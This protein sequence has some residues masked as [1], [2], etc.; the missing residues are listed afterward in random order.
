MTYP[1]P[2]TVF[3][4][5]VQRSRYFIDL[6]V[7]DL[8]GVNATRLWGSTN[9]DDAYGTLATSGI[10]GTGGTAFAEATRG[11]SFVSR[12]LDRTQLV[13]E[14]HRGM[15]RYYF[16]PEDFVNPA[17][18][19]PMPA[20]D[21]ILFVRL[22]QSS[23]AAGGFLSVP[24]AAPINPSEPIRGPILVIPPV[25]FW[26]TGVPALSLA[27]LAPSNTGCVVGQIPVVDQTV[28]TPLPLHIVLPRPARLITISN[29]GGA[30]VTLLASSGLG[31]PM[32]QIDSGNP[33]NFEGGIREIVLARAAGGAGCSFSIFATIGMEA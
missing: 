27:G 1:I 31:M 13:E 22:Q 2:F 23:L 24:V 19:S 20:D 5:I 28:Q 12:T 17:L 29:T 16:N 33:L 15:T 6:Q 11:T 14:S 25:M 4:G 9:L 30:G 26:Q 3:P 7:R 32:V 18:P 8:P 21:A 10:A